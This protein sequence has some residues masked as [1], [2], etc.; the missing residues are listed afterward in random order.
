M[1]TATLADVMLRELFCLEFM[2]CSGSQLFC[3]LLTCDAKHRDITANNLAYLLSDV[4][5]FFFFFLNGPTIQAL[6][7]LD[8]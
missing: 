4:A 6:I 1:L 5:G 7:I 8:D 3:C 2:S